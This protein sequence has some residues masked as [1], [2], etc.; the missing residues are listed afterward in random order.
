MS[1]LNAPPADTDGRGSALFRIRGNQV[2]WAL[3]WSNIAAPFVGHIHLAPAGV[4]GPVVVPFFNGTLP[5]TVNAAT[6][7]TT[8]T[9]ENVAAI[10]ANPAGYYANLHNVDF[11]GGAIRAQLRVVRHD[12]DL[13]ARYHSGKLLGL[14]DGGQEIP[15]PGDVDGR[16]STFFRISRTQVSYSILF[17]G[18]AP[19]TAGHIHAARTGA[20]GPIVVPLFAAPTGLPTA[21]TGIAGVVPVTPELSRQISRDPGGFYSNLHNAE[22]PAGAIRSQ[23]F[24]VN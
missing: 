9:A 11:P 3:S 18:I 20:A 8:S 14:L 10:I 13:L 15:G 22:F 6:G 5:D 24:Q 7:C 1:G 19:P 21:I 23:L 2:C 16:A 12:Q 4:N 17:G